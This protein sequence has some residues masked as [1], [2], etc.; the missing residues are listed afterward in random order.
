MKIKLIRIACYVSL[1]WTTTSFIQEGNKESTIKALDKIL[2]SCSTEVCFTNSS[3]SPDNK[4]ICCIS[5][6]SL[7]FNED[8]S[9]LIYISKHYYNKDN[10]LLE[11]YT[12]KIKIKDLDFNRIEIHSISDG[13]KYVGI[14]TRDLKKTFVTTCEGEA[15]IGALDYSDNTSFTFGQDCM[16]DSL[17]LKF[18]TLFKKLQP[19]N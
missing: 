19:K 1:L 5:K 11:T 3:I 14:Y 17:H 8:K 13:N 10:R 4:V 12:T 6:S 9:Q 2:N 18:Q 15:C 7:K 16:A